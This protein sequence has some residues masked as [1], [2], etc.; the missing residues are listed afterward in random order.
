MNMR[1]FCRGTRKS[2]VAGCL[3]NEMPWAGDSVK[4]DHLHDTKPILLPREAPRHI[5]MS[6]VSRV[7]KLS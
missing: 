7:T 1:E 5:D 3:H 2:A 6:R 4:L